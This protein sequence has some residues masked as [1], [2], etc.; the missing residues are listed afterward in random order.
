[1]GL[2]WERCPALNKL[3]LKFVAIGNTYLPTNH[4]GEA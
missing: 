4:H 3:F 1:M 2:N